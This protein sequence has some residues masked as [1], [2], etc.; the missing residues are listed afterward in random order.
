MSKRESK[1]H[2][3]ILNW[4]RTEDLVCIRSNL[5]LKYL[6]RE[7]FVVHVMKEHWGGGVLLQPFLPSA[8]D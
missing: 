5:Y 8:G 4:S 6:K 1:F 3:L 2:K 7:M